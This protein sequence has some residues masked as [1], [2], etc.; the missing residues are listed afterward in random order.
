MDLIVYAIATFYCQA[1]KWSAFEK[2]QKSVMF[3]KLNIS[4]MIYGKRT[5]L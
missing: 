1:F 5:S 3:T 2:K 4:H